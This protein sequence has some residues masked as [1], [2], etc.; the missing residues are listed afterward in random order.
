MANAVTINTAMP[1]A[2]AQALLNALRE[3]YRTSLNEHWYDDRFRQVAAGL[4][5][6]AILA[7][8]PVMSAQKRLM[9]ALASSL[10]TGGRS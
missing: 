2:E 3:Q 8:K 6:G 10:K 5:H 9:A 4:R 7:D 1:P